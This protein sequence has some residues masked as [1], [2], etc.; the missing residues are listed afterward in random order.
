VDTG[1]R[2]RITGEGEAGTGGGGP[3]DLYVVIHVRNHELFQRQGADLSCTVPITFSQ[4]ALGAELK[5]PTLLD[6]EEALK[7]PPGTQS[8]TVF[9]LQGLGIPKLGQSSRG[10]LY[11]NVRVMT[12]TH[13]T[14]EQKRLLE[15]FAKLEGNGEEE[16]KSILDKMKELFT[17]E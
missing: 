15:E 14:R 6:S 11:V 1:S 16:E 2:L 8:G 7:I 3:G 5:I 9:R 12:P 13:L 4:A 10:D 17:G